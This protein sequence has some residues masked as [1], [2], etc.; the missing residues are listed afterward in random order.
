M[1]HS[2]FGGSYFVSVPSAT[3]SVRC[4]LHKTHLKTAE[5]AK[6]ADSDSEDENKKKKTHQEKEL[7]VGDKL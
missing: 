5:E 2:I 6:A 3:G 1:T 7:A 4:F